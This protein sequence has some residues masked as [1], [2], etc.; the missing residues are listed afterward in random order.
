MIELNEAPGHALVPV[1]LRE[2]READEPRVL[3]E[4]PVDITALRSEDPGL[5]EAWRC[6]VGQAFQRAF[7]KSYRAVHFVRDHSTV[8]RRGFY[9][10]ERL[11]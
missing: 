5:A 9:V 10:L 1:G 2:I 4:I 7:E 3:I 8:L 6:L 11:Y